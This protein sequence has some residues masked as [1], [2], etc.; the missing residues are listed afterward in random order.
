MQLS[1]PALSTKVQPDVQILI[2]KPY[3]RNKCNKAQVILSQRSVLAPLCPP[4][5]AGSP[6]IRQLQWLN[7]S[8]CPV[9]ILPM[10]ASPIL[11]INRRSPLATLVSER[12]NLCQHQLTS[13][14]GA[15]PNHFNPL[16][17]LH[18]HQPIVTHCDLILPS[19]NHRQ[20]VGQL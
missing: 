16:E 9:T 1:L 6:V 19:Q 15:L 8:P 2:M 20:A 14:D 18:H 12:R 17:F 5:M 7:H 13:P 11:W 3:E 4:N 10:S